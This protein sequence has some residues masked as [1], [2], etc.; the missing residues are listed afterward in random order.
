MRNDIYM[1]TRGR[2]DSQSKAYTKKKHVK[3]MTPDVLFNVS[4]ITRGITGDVQTRITHETNVM[5]T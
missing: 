3:T 4:T 5:F 2:N 1:I